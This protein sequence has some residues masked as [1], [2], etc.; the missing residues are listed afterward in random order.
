MKIMRADFHA[1]ALDSS[2]EGM[3]QL[4]LHIGKSVG[5]HL[6]EQ[7]RQQSSEYLSAVQETTQADHIFTIDKHAEEI[8]VPILKQYAGELGGV[9][10]LAEGIGDEKNGMNLPDHEGN[11]LWTVLMDPIDGTRCLMYDKR[12]AFFL[13]AAAPYSSSRRPKIS[14]AEVSVLVELPTSKSLYADW[15]TFE[16]SSGIRAK[17]R[18]L[19]TDEEHALALRPSKA[20]DLAGGFGQLVRFFPP[21]RELLS[22]LED[23]LIKQTVPN[24]D[25]S[26]AMVFEDQ[27]ISTGGQL[28]QLLMGQDRFIGDVRGRLYRFLQSKG[29][30]SGHTAHS[31]DLAAIPIAK[32]A[33]LELT[34][35]YGAELEFSFDVYEKV[36]WIGYAN[37]SLRSLIEPKLLPLLDDYL[38]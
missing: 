29:I 24:F 38:A 28:Y 10:L 21:G 18:N 16:R 23:E 31:Y 13:A 35:A 26:L 27:Y 36:D 4:L 6:I 9:Q 25:P 3:S 19:L 5:N 15:I 12:S 1:G 20:V 22:K 17:R 11:I 33:G 32:A 7:V 14:E 2:A 30:P 37:S 8:I 34:D